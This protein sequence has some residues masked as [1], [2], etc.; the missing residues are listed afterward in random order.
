MNY[1][2]PN[3]TLRELVYILVKRCI[4]SCSYRFAEIIN[5]E[6][7]IDNINTIKLFT[8]SINTMNSISDDKES[9]KHSI[10]Y[11]NKFRNKVEHNNKFLDNNIKDKLGLLLTS[12]LNLNRIF[13]LCYFENTIILFDYI[14]RSFRDEFRYGVIRN[15][16]FENNIVCSALIAKNIDIIVD[17]S[18]QSK[19]KKVLY[20]NIVYNVIQRNG[21][22]SPKV[23]IN[24]TSN[25]FL[26]ETLSDALSSFIRR[27]P[28]DDSDR[29]PSINSLRR[30]SVIKYYNKDK[31]FLLFFVGDKNN[32]IYYNLDNN[33]YIR[34]L[35]GYELDA[36]MVFCY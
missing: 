3:P 32:I 33:K 2:N 29:I 19:Y 15:T 21:I 8:N 26:E 10:H 12:Y 7:N 13:K 9:V 6:C 20:K 22:I 11:I 14:F 23:R 35:T 5:L 25:I 24:I 27:L 16:T 18:L 4:N 30:Y 1:D 34:D 17:F 28:L 31:E 36:I